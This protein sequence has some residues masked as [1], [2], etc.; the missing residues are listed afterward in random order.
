MI[1]YILCTIGYSYCNC[2]YVCIINLFICYLCQ[3]YIFY[4]YIFSEFLMSLEL[5]QPR[6]PSDPQRGLTLSITSLSSDMETAGRLLLDDY[7][8]VESFISSGANFLKLYNVVI[9]ICTSFRIL[10]LFHCLINTMER[11]KLQSLEKVILCTNI[12]HHCLCSHC[13]LLGL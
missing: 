1:V 8:E 9:N 10:H 13:F 6:R 11:G 2:I 7:V 12:C 4:V 3:Q 5:S